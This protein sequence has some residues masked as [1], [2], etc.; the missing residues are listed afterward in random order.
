[1]HKIDYYA[2]RPLEKYARCKCGFVTKFYKNMDDVE[3]EV[4]GHM[5]AIERLKLQLGTRTPSVKSQRDYFRK[6]AENEHISPK[7]RRLWG[8]L[9]DEL[10]QR[11]GDD[12]T[13]DN[14]PSLF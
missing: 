7:D 3:D 1:M 8:I 4:R 2:D 14:H 9:A 6:M 5:L 13:P 10:D 12:V 11:I